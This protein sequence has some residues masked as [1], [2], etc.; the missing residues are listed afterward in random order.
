MPSKNNKK[1]KTAVPVEN[2]N[3]FYKAGWQPSIDIDPNTGRGEVVHVGTNPNYENDFDKIIEKWGFDPNIYEIDG[4][5]KVSSWNAQLK[6][7]LLR[8]STHLK[9]LYAGNLQLTTNITTPC[10][11]KQ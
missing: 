3:N 10:L 8:P 4:I 7:A 9:E 6:A 11:N 2:A 5:L 1:K